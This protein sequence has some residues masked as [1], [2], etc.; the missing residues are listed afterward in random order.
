[1][2]RDTVCLTQVGELAFGPGVA[3]LVADALAA[4]RLRSALV[5][6]SASVRSH[7]DAISGDIRRAGVRVD[8]WEAPEREPTVADFEAAVRHA[9]ASDADAVIGVGGGS[10]MDLAKLVAALATS[11]QKLHDVVGIGKLDGRALWLACLPTT[12]GTGSEV[13][14]IAILLDEDDLLK[15]GVVSPHLV[16]DGAYVDPLLTVTMPPSVTASTGLD[17]LT[18]CIEAYANRAAHPLVDTLALEGVRLIARGLL[19]AVRNGSDV[20]ART[21]MSRGSLNGG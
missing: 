19:K 21:D 13:S 17:A 7:A 18:H 16:P 9:R 2:P 1:M 10:V 4:Q 6:T 8:I 20:S 11:E 15:K 5:L 12:A 3:R 14:P